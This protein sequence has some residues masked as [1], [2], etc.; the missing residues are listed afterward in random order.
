MSINKKS[1]SQIKELQ[2][3]LNL[4]HHIQEV[5]FTANGDHYFHAHEFTQKGEKKPTLYG[6]LKSEP[7][8]KKVQGTREIYKIEP[9]H[10][11]EA[12]IIETVSR[13]EILAMEIK[14]NENLTKKDQKIVDKLQSENEALRAKL[15]EAGIE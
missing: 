4:C 2:N 3:T 15:K 13:E 10:T 12:E 7:V 11:P 8:L 9:V 1:Q 14:D 5:H 6:R